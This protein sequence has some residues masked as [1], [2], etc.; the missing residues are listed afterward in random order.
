MRQERRVGGYHDDDRT[1]PGVFASLVRDLRSLTCQ[2]P[3]LDALVVRVLSFGLE[4]QEAG[5]RAC[6]NAAASLTGHT[7]TGLGVVGS[8]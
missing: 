8:S 1:L 6:E 3:H 4:E 2:D 7:A 5:R